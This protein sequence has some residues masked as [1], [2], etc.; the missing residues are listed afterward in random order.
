MEKIIT[1]IIPAYNVEKYLSKCLNSFLD[2]S[3]LDKMEVIIVNDGSTDKTEEIAKSYVGRYP[4]SYKLINKSN[5]GHGSAINI[6]SQIACGKYF[7]VIDA[8]DWVI[9]ENLRRFISR[10]EELDVDIVVTPF[11]MIDMKT[12]RSQEQSFRSS[13]CIVN[14]NTIISDWSNYEGC[15]VFHG[16]T[17]QTVFYQKYEHLL[18]HHIF[19]E[20]QEFSS[21]PCC[22]AE[23]IALINIFIYQYMIGNVEQSI[24]AE[25]QAKR[26]DHVEQVIDNMLHYYNNGVGMSQIA[27]E[28]L[29]LKIEN[30]ILV[31]YMVA[32]IYEQDKI[33]GM[34]ESLALNQ[35]IQKNN[36]EMITRLNRKYRFYLLMNRMHISPGM[37]QWI[38]RPNCYG[39]FKYI[40]NKCIRRV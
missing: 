28:Y 32:C 40:L 4:D 21:I 9:T 35:K 10:L 31:Y 14:L 1:F 19:Y 20:D 29:G 11:H 7:K 13:D 16:I 23:N 37:Y 2:L 18:P 17:Y 39:R 6:G 33:K 27:Q 36:S 15:M 22:H 25:S 30:I 34:H 5:G 24:A 12:G 3:I 26:I 8:D 38:M